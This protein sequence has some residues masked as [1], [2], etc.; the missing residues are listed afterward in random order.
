MVII[1]RAKAD[2]LWPY[3]I[4]LVAYGC[5]HLKSKLVLDWG[6][7]QKYKSDVNLRYLQKSMSL[8]R[9]REARQI[10]IEAVGPAQF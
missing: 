10:D 9:S 5:D 2:I 6:D 7:L 1:S 8:C 3:G 4:L